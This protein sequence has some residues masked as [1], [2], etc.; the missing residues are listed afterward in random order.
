MTLS[1]LTGPK[2]LAGQS[3]SELINC[4]GY[5]VKRIILPDGWTAAPLTFQ[6]SPDGVNFHD[7]HHIQSTSGAFVAYELIIPTVT[8]GAALAMP[9]NTGEMMSWIRLR[10]GTAT[11]PIIQT[12]DRLFGLEVFPAVTG[13][14]AEGPQGPIGPAG[15]TGAQGVAGPSGSSGLIGPTGPTGTASLMGITNASDALPGQ[16][17]EVISA[18]NGTGIA[19]V[20]N[21]PAN[22]ITL[23]LTPGDWNV[24]SITTFTPTS[25]P[26]GLASGIT[27]TSGT[28]PTN[29]EIVAGTG[30][31]NQLWASSMPSGKVQNIPTSLVRVNTNVPKDVYLVVMASFGGGAVQATGYMSARRIR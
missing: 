30:I 27:L 9:A 3:L 22:L 10:S 4:D 17:G 7:L 31:L 11:V 6:V 16:I 29:P 13:G 14:G 12:A 26:N 18:G 23:H 21:I 15:P 8:P 2:I 1:V 5:Q 19:L 20:T 25:G 28:L 24:G